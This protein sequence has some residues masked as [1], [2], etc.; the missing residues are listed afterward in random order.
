MILEERNYTM[1][2]AKKALFLGE[3]QERGLAIQ[4]RHLERLVGYF[5]TEF[6]VVNQIVHMWAYQSLADRAERRGALQRDPEWKKF[7]SDTLHCVERMENRILVP[8]VFSPLGWGEV[9]RVV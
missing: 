3:Y 2:P 7:V 9:E 1:M 8:T 6:G 4:R 5:E